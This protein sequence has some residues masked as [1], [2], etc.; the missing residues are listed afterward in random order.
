MLTVSSPDNLVASQKCAN[1]GTPHP[2]ARLGR[3]LGPLSSQPIF[4]LPGKL[5]AFELA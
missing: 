4:K 3:N 5:L 2:R 1:A